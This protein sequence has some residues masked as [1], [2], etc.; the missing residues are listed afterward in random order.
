MLMMM[1]MLIT[2]TYVLCCE[3]KCYY[4]IN[5]LEAMFNSIPSI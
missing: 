4:L 3:E 5:Y 2:L 1:M